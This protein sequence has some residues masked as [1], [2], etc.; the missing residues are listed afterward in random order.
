MDQTIN[1]VAMTNSDNNKLRD[2]SVIKKTETSVEVVSYLKNYNLDAHLPRFKTVLSRHLTVAAVYR[3]PLFVV[4]SPSSKIITSNYHQ[5][6]KITIIVHFPR[7]DPAH[8]KDLRRDKLICSGLKDA[9]RSWRIYGM[10]QYR[11]IDP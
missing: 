8:Q 10:Y 11:C 6:R 7:T 2:K 1:S 4:E 9:I 5:K 3:L